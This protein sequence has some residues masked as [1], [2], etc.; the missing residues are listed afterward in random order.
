[1]DALD[2]VFANRYLIAYYDWRADR[3][4]P[5]AWQAAF[6][7]CVSTPH[8]V[9]QHLLLGMNAHINLDLGLAVADIALP[10]RLAVLHGDFLKINDI[11]LQMIDGVQDALALSAP[12][13]GRLDRLGG[14]LDEMIT[15]RVICRAR[16]HAWQVANDLLGAEQMAKPHLIAQ[17]DKNAQ[18]IANRIMRAGQLSHKVLNSLWMRQPPDPRLLIEHLRNA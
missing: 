7:A 4:I 11:L 13:L 3:P 15:H 2:T 5:L 1:M 18:A 9:Y 6:Q 8:L 17:V 16:K 12:W 10:G 14:Q